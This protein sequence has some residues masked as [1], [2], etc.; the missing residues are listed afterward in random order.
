MPAF[1]QTRSQ[2]MR[3]ALKRRLA[4]L[5]FEQLHGRVKPF[6]AKRGYLTDEDIFD[7]VS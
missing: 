4:P 6:A 2:V 7:R 5:R 1:G 3:E